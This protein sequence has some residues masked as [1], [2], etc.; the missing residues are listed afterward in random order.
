MGKIKKR[1]L[2][3]KDE[4]ESRIR[5]AIKTIREGSGISIREAAATYGLAYTT[6]RYRL[7]GGQTHTISHQ[8]QQLLTDLDEK[9]ILRWISK[10]ELWGFPPTIQHVKEAAKHLSGSDVGKNWITRFLNRHPQLGSKFTTQIDK[11]RINASTPE[12]IKHHFRRLGAV[13]R[14]HNL[15]GDDIFNMDEKGFMIGLAARCKVIYNQ[16]GHKGP[17][18]VAEDGNRELLTVIECVSAS[19]VV[20]PPLIIYKGSNHYMGWHQFTRQYPEAAEFQFSYSPKGWTSRLLGFEWIKQ[21]FHPSTMSASC[22]PRLLIIDGHDSHVCI[23]F[24]TFCEN[25]NI[26]PYCLPPHTTHLLQPLD[27]GLFS[28]LQHYYGKAVDRMV[29]GNQAIKKANFL[30][31]YIEARKQAYINTNIVKAFENGLIMHALF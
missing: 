24:V 30:P 18:K 22:R 31:L 8:N 17:I 6:L 16:L 23:D 3:A 1:E 27:V 26:I 7:I 25:N 11:K 28:P 21:L 20:L 14:E 13:I 10:L 29:R 9:A 2:I 12:V 19:G 15:T 5:N 4:K